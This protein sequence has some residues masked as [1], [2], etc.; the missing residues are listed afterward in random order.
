MRRSCLP[1]LFGEL[2]ERRKAAVKRSGLARRRVF[3]CTDI[4]SKQRRHGQQG[5]LTMRSG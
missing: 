5:P 1:H 3:A 2:V 4:V